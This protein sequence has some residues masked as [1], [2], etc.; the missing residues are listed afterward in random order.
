MD[1]YESRLQKALDKQLCGNRYYAHIASPLLDQYPQ[2]NLRTTEKKSENKSV[3]I[4]SWVCQALDEIAKQEGTSLSQLI[5]NAVVN[6]LVKHYDLAE[7]RQ[8]YLESNVAEEKEPHRAVNELRQL[9]LDMQN[10]KN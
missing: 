10:E 1:K 4:P 2:P 9:L 5:N 6:S 3:R 7:A 8:I